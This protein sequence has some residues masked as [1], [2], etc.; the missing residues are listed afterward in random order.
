MLFRSTATFEAVADALV[1]VGAHRERCAEVDAG[2]AKTMPAA[3]ED[4]RSIMGP[5]LLARLQAW[6][7][8]GELGKV[9][10]RHTS[11]T[12][13]NLSICHY[14]WHALENGEIRA[15][16]IQEGSRYMFGSSNRYW[17]QKNSEHIWNANQAYFNLIMKV[18][19]KSG[20]LIRQIL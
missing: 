18:K 3:A 5:D 9:S 13:F 14:S 6:D 12:S 16:N 15:I 17:T 2:I 11:Q 1:R 8:A 10:S 7:E 19:T 4:L 20:N